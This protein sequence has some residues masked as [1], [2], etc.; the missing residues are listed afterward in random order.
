MEILA[1]ANAGNTSRKQ[2]TFSRRL[3][4]TLLAAGLAITLPAAEPTKAQLDFFESKIR[5]VF[6]DNC[7]KC[8]SAESGK[9]KGDLAL[10]TREG[11]ARGGE[12]GAVIVP[13]DPAK[14]L[15]IKAIGYTDPD[16]Q[17]PPK[18]E[19]LTDAQIADLTA[20]VKMGAPDPR[21]AKVIGGGKYNGLTDTARAHWAFQSLK[22]PSVPEVKQKDW[23][24]TPVDAFILAKLE[25]NQMK[26]SPAADKATLIRRATFDLI[27]LP[28][29][30]AEVKG[31]LEDNSP[32]AFAKVVDRLL[33]SPHYGERW[34]RYWLDTARYADTKGNNKRTEDF[35][36]PY[37]WTYRDYVINAF[38]QD[39]PYDRF[40][41]EQLAA[42]KLPP[43]KDPAKREA[44]A[45]L[46]FL[47]LGDRFDGNNNDVINDRIDVIT[48]GT[49]GLTVACARCHDHMF[50]PIPTK[51][52]YSLYG[53]FASC[54]EPK[55]K[56]L[57]QEITEGPA[58]KDYL[59]KHE[60]AVKEFHAYVDK[61]M[62]LL[63]SD[64]RQKAGSYLLFTRM[65][66]KARSEFTT[67]A[68][69]TQ[70]VIQLVQGR[71]ARARR[72]DPVL[73]PWKQFAS[74]PEKNFAQEAKKL[75]AKIGA[76]K[77]FKP[78]I[79]PYVANL[80]KAATP[81][82][83]GQVA[84]Y[85]TML[86]A[87][88]DQ[89]WQA[90]AAAAERRGTAPAPLT[91]P[92]LDALRQFPFKET[93]SYSL[94]A[95]EA[96]QRLPNRLRGRATQLLGKINEIDM[97]HPAAPARAMAIVDADRPKDSPVFIRGE[98][99]NKG[100]VAPRRFLQILSGP[101]RPVFKNG[102]GRLELA[103]AIASKDNPLT[104]RVMVNRIWLHHF[105][106]GFVTTPDDFGTQSAPPS[107][108]ELLDYLAARFMDEG[109]SLKKLHRLILL[110]N[111]YQ[112]SS[113]NN[114]HYAQI[115]PYNRLLWRANIRRLEFEALRDSL[116]AIGGKLDPAVG[117]KPVNITSEPYSTR[118]TVYGYIDRANLPEV[119]NHFDFANPDMTTGK[120]YDTIVPQQALFLMN[121]PLVIAQSR[122]LV[123]RSEFAELKDETARIAL[124][125]QLIYQR[126]PRPE[127]IKLGRDF[128]AIPPSKERVINAVQPAPTPKA[129]AKGN[130]KG[131]SDGPK[132]AGK[133]VE[134]RPLNAWEEYA[135]ALLLANEA[136]YVN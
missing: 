60:A 52:Y 50:D 47:T 68:K 101:N 85:Y 45:A 98:A 58:Y 83:L 27:G 117:G 132:N 111:V 103:R 14:S 106:E 64:F 30:P 125:Y 84:G 116:L 108:P 122:N 112:Q 128:V 34:G 46:G 130:P 36:Y 44:L 131:K 11:V 13:G 9:T 99:E 66:G 23:V 118:R 87:K 102:S 20:W 95:E 65:E 10:D 74:L 78:P 107:H 134:R 62:N 92:N 29:T 22:K 51:D 115:D 94:E 38:N 41:I 54:I 70:N 71:I 86:F 3:T 136:S 33:A 35:R 96:V 48:K 114:P 91:D 61:N 81:T 123:A 82:T 104:A 93:S 69:L 21:I 42:D 6:A 40:I 89:Q 15:L 76:N 16:L 63:L 110:S 8:H 129:M 5:P 59:K 97:T 2:K 100:E 26:P 119:L 80:F 135:Q 12:Q 39:M 28:P 109:W 18:G 37:A 56:P 90:V 120:R 19:K 55:E 32:Q 79:N 4:L 53:I 126:A 17:M 113:G 105:G 121:S 133:M 1:D 75:A 43:G 73:G 127:E 25:Q 7:Y 49:L 31:F 77:D 124:L 88:A 57:L 67:K 72:E 24:S